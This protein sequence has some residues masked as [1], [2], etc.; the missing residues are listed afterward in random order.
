MTL[1]DY[2]GAFLLGDALPI[3]SHSPPWW[4]TPITSNF[5]CAHYSPGWVTGIY[6]QQ[7]SMDTHLVAETMYL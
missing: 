2:H 4:S 6:E 1:G 7:A 5:I 3:Y